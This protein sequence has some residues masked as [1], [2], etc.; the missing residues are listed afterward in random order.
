M[1]DIPKGLAHWRQ[2][3]GGAA[4][5]ASLSAIVESCSRQWEFEPGPPFEPASVS[6]VLPVTMRDGTPAVLKVNFPEWE[7][8]LEPDALAHWAGKGAVRLLASDPNQRALLVERCQPGTQLW[9]LGGRP[10]KMTRQHESGPAWRVVSGVRRLP[11]TSF[12]SCRTRR[13]VGLGSCR[14][15]TR[16]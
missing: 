13:N 3:P 11:A 2:R 7:S 10:V 14:Y 1:I 4:W 16:R 9:E 12:D 8:E 15:S 5:L 6:L